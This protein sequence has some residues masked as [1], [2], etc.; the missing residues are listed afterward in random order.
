[1]RTIKVVNI[2]SLD[3]YYEGPVN[4]VMDLPM[5]EAF[6]SY[7][8]E[9]FDA[10]DITLIGSTSFRG[11]STYW[12]PIENAPEPAPG[13]PMARAYDA[14]NRGISHNWNTKPVVVVSDSYEVPADNPLVEH[15]RVI[16]RDEVAAWKEAGDEEV[17]VFASHVLW[18][19]L[20]Q[21]GLVDE[22]HVM[23]GATALCGG[24]PLFTAPASLTLKDARRFDGSDNVLLV[25]A[26]R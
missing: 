16:G 22:V 21:Q 14:S 23:Q 1:M 8:L 10:A 6:D 4:G 15:T 9:R 11:M 17:V 25:Y 2:A 12:P 3:G 18:N 13:D 24:T 5:D 20:L 19:H 7:N 26:A